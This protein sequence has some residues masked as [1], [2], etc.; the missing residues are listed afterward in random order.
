MK[1]K[2]ARLI[3]LSGS[4]WLSL[5]FPHLASAQSVTCSKSMTAK[6]CDLLAE[7]VEAVLKELEAPAD[8][9][10]VILGGRD[11]RRATKMFKTEKNTSAAF[12]VFEIR[13]TFFSAEYL[14]RRR[15]EVPTE[16]IAHELAHILCNCRS[17]MKARKLGSTL[18]ARM[19]S[20]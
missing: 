18:M 9:T 2:K 10:W 17:E 11:W 20:E 7:P 15:P 16:V 19:N 1:V 3:L 6:S 14:Q 5:F 4:I 8:W 12:T 13:T